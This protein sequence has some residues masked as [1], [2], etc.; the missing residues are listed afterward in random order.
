LTFINKIKF[1]RL[2]MKYQKNRMRSKIKIMKMIMMKEI[3]KLMTPTKKLKLIWK[4]WTKLT[5]KTWKE[6]SKNK[7]AK[8]T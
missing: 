8:T 2:P 6:K 3:I 1:K 7:M 5:R 4:E